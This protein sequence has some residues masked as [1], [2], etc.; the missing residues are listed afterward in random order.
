MCLYVP[1]SISAQLKS[2]T[3]DAYL[4]ELTRVEWEIFSTSDE[5]V[6]ARLLLTKSSIHGS[7]GDYEQALATLDRINSYAL[8]DSSQWEVME[9]RISLLYLNGEFEQA[10]NAILEASVLGYP[11][12]DDLRLI[13]V[14]NYI[15]LMDLDQAGS[16]YEKLNPGGDVSEVF[17]AKKFRKPTRAFNLSLLLP[18]SGQMYSGHVLRGVT[19]L[20]IQ[21]FL[22]TYGIRGI[23]GRYFF[24]EALPSVAL[25]QGFYFGGAEFARELTEKRN[26]KI[27]NELSNQ[28]LRSF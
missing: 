12:N 27:V 15:S 18:G 17:R 11:Q 3:T 10:K 28:V 2:V 25:F 13:E 7:G 9:E 20:G 1:F 21:A 23:Q 19:S 6:I 22:F 16:L 26:R 14:L 5:S 24:T 8:D 4:D